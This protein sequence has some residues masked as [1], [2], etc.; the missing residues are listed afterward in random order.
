MNQVELFFSIPH[1]RV[2]KNSVHNST[3]ELDHDVY[4]FLDH[5]NR[6]ERSPFR[7]TFTGYPLQVGDRA[8]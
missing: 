2:L 7:W 4:A 6:V 5:W 1:R 3:D 8:A